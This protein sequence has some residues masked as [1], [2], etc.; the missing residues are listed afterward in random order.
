[1]QFEGHELFASILP[2]NLFVP[3]G[4]QCI[5]AMQ[6][7]SGDDATRAFL[8]GIGDPDSHVCLRAEREFLRLLNCDCNQPVGVLAIVDR[9]VMRVRAQVFQPDESHPREAVVE[10]SRDETD[11]LAAELL[12]QINGY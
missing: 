2:R 8:E 12:R 3:A 10:G 9:N 7:R 5:I 11:R 6:I 1:M 4:G